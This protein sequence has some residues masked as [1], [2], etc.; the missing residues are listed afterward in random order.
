[1]SF[2]FNQIVEKQATDILSL[3]YKV[4]MVVGEL[5]SQ[6]CGL[7]AYS[8]NDIKRCSYLIV[9]TGKRVSKPKCRFFPVLSRSR[10][11]HGRK[12]WRKYWGHNS[13]S[14]S[15]ITRKP[16]CRKETARCRTCSWFKVRRRHYYKFKSSQA[17]KARL[18]SS[19]HT[20]TKQ[21]LTQKLRF[22]IILK[23]RVLESVERR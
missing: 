14:G 10:S 15:I 5:T 16:C 11:S 7:I 3:Y 1:V 22:K 4:M 17:S 12:T 23:S 19:K 13:V 21:N 9:R 20:G 2:I 8:V 6:V 18:Q